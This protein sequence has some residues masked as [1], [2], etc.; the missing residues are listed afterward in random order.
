M[1]RETLSFIIL[2]SVKK[3]YKKVSVWGFDIMDRLLESIPKNLMTKVSYTG[4]GK[5][6]KH[7]N[8]PHTCEV[9]YDKENQRPKDRDLPF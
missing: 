9:L 7:G 6:N 8:K 1:K 3:I 5:E 4:L 2:K